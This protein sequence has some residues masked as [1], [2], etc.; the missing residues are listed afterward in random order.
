[1]ESTCRA[2]NN[3]E[4]MMA[5]HC[6]APPVFFFLLVSSLEKRVLSQ[7]PAP[8]QQGLRNTKLA[9]TTRIAQIPTSSHF[10]KKP[11][12][13]SMFQIAGFSSS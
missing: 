9:L 1:G 13:R 7:G 11:T 10:H 5:E 6:A 2:A 3:V 4:P 12:G 8:A